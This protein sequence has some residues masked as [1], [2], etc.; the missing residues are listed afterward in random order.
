MRISGLVKSLLVTTVAATSLMASPADAATYNSDPA[1]D[2]DSGGSAPLSMRR[3]ADIRKIA[4]WTSSGRAYLRVW[5]GDVSSRDTS[6]TWQGHLNGT[7]YAIYAR[8]GSVKPSMVVN[9]RSRCGSSLREAWNESTNTAT[10]SVPISCFPSGRVIKDGRLFA[11]AAHRKAIPRAWA[12][13]MAY[14]TDLR[15]R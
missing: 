4:T 15:V 5:L 9:S 12:N 1:G 7:Y 2:Q 6:I 13:D 3:E 14:I 11:T 10:V 8:R